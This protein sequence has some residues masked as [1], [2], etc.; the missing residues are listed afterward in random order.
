MKNHKYQT[1]PRAL[2]IIFSTQVAQ[3]LNTIAIQ[4]LAVAML[5]PAFRASILNVPDL[6]LIQQAY[7]KAP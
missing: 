1:R 7:S 4:I 2:A 5:L 3:D 6:G